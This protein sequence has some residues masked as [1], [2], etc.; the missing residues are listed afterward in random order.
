[1]ARFT[2]PNTTISLLTNTSKMPSRSWSLP[3][4][5]ACPGAKYGANSICGTCYAQKG[6][7]AWGPVKRAQ[8]ARFEFAIQASKDMTVGLQF[9]TLMVQAITA[10]ARRQQTRHR[11]QHGNLDGF[12]PVFR[13]HDSGDLFSP[14]YTRLWIAIC[15]QLPTVRFWFP[16]RSYRIPNLMP[17]LVTLAA[18]PNVSVRP[19]ALHFGEAAPVIVG[20]SAGTTAATA[21]FTCPASSQDGKCL[22]CRQC[23]TTDVVVSY[24]KH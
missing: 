16:T 17:A 15:R 13:V 4:G 22:D 3:A 7:Y 9:V 19:S 18:L 21:G 24:R 12:V 20:L 5:R 23:W 2:V 10:E 6:A 11:R 1:M 8:Q 14:A